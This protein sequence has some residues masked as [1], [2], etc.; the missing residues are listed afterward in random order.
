[1]SASDLRRTAAFRASFARRQA[2]EVRESEGCVTVLDPD[3]AASHEHNQL[4][5]DGSP[6]PSELLARALPHRR[7]T[8]L[9]DAVGAACAPVLTTAGYEH[10]AELVMTYSGVGAKTGAGSAA[11]ADL[12]DL[13]PALTR[14]LRIW[15]PNASQDVVRQLAE[16]R[17]AR[18]RGADDVRFIAARAAD[19]TIASWAD[20]YLDEDR[21]IAQIED[22]VTADA[23]TRC[24]HADAVLA[25]ALRLAARS[26]DLFFLIADAEDWPHTWYARRGFTPIGRSH[27]FTR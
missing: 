23:H 12:A 10:E 4:V 20:L 13:L 25:T 17:T 7:I 2:A 27:V 16:R 18:R 21:R 11:E 14:Q 24:G 9:D 1:M 6:S 22:L 15:M 19:G 3:Y 26:C 5:V 8:V